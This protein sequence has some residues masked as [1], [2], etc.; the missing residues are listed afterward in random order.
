M[1]ITAAKRRA[2]SSSARTGEDRTRSVKE[3]KLL[4]EAGDGEVHAHHLSFCGEQ[5]NAVLQFHW[6]H[7][8]SWLIR[9]VNATNSPEI[10][11]FLHCRRLSKFSSPCDYRV[12]AGARCLE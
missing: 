6:R 9:I 10:K 2:P 3:G 1:S 5:G 8:L 4:V 11:G 7:L 12:E